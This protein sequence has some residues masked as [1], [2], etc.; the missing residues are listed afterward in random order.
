MLLSDFQVVRKRNFGGYSGG[1]NFP[2]W[3]QSENRKQGLLLLCFEGLSI[4]TTTR[5]TIDITRDGGIWKSNP[6]AGKGV[7]APTQ[8]ECWMDQP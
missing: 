7:G 4:I 8:S 2:N 1:I 3:I 5:K 6:M